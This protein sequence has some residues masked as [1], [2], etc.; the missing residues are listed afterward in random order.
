MRKILY[1]AL[2]AIAGL[3]IT[4]CTKVIDVNLNKTEPVIVI[5]G[6]ITDTT[7]PYTVKVTKTID[8]DKDNNFPGVSGAVVTIA[9][10]AGNSETLTDM[11]SGGIYETRTLQGTPGRTYTLTVVVEGKTYTATST[12]PAKV[13]FDSVGYKDITTPEGTE[14]YPTVYYKDPVGKGN[15]YRAK[16]YIAGVFDGQIFVESDEFIDGKKR[17]AILFNGPDDDDDNI[18][19]T[20]GTI[21]I[22]MQCIDKKNFEYLEQLIEADGNSESATPSNPVTNISNGA[23][24]YFSAHTSSFKTLPLPPLLPL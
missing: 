10:D 7:G 4:S 14:P 5:Q 8:I 11:G 23:L 24:G 21:T 13:A 9:D 1:I 18:I 17:E 22:E 15:Y 3:S 6:E 19:T 12:M 20:L 16:Q 2:T